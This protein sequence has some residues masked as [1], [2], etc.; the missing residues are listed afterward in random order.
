MDVVRTPL[1]SEIAP[2]HAFLN[3]LDLRSFTHH[4]TVHRGGDHL[5]TTQA[6]TDWLRK[7]GLLAADAAAS[8]DDLR[9]A[10]RLRAQLRGSLGQRAQS[11]GPLEERP[12]PEGS[13]P[14]NLRLGTPPGQPPALVP[15]GAGAQGALER[16]ALLVC[17]A[18]AAGTWGR[19]K[20]C[21]AADCQWVFYDR[22]KPGRG[23]WCAAELCGNRMK[24]RAYRE[25]QR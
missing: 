9:H 8:E 23:R 21:E 25:R 6:L 3:S 15:V 14:L 2:L 19:L 4:G 24:T 10:R 7:R 17:E 16:I 13:V 1:P 18:V 11:P 12:G 22:S 5:S 20:M